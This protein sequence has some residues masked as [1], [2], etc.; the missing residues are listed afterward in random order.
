MKIPWPTRNAFGRNGMNLLIDTNIALYLFAGEKQVA[1]FLEGQTIYISF[2]TELELLGYPNITAKEEKVIQDFLNECVIIDVN[3]QIKNKAI[4]FRKEYNLKLPDT[5]IAA[6]THYLGI[7]LFS[8]D[9]D[10][11]NI[12]EIN[13]IVYNPQ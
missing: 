11:V 1:E 2:I 4:F 13:L 3:K 8:A 6:T 7:P 10:F 9:R 12:G 5:I